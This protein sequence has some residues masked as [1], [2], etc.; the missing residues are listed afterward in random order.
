MHQYADGIQVYV[1]MTV[2]D[3]AS[4]A[5]SS[6][7]VS[8]SGASADDRFATCAACLTEIEAWLRA[9]RLILNSTKN[10]GHVAGFKS[11]AH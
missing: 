2:D 8:R 11:T 6:T 1:S 4:E 9:S 3:A 7:V 10:P 5:A